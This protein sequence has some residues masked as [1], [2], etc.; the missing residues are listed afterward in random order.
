MTR[1]EKYLII[2]IVLGI[3]LIMFTISSDYNYLEETK[4]SSEYEPGSDSYMED[5]LAYSHPDWSYER[6]CEEL[7]GIPVAQ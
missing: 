3:I 1:K 6:I 5:S 2:G 4:F 7:Y